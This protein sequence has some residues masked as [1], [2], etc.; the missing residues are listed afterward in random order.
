MLDV[1]PTCCEDFSA[2]ASA[3][4][5]VLSSWK[6]SRESLVASAFVANLCT[7]VSFACSCTHIMQLSDMSPA[8]GSWMQTYQDAAYRMHLRNIAPCSEWNR[9]LHC[10]SK[11]DT[12][13]A[14]YNFNT[15]QLILVIFGRDVADRV[16]YGMVICY[17]TSPN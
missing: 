4:L 5:P 6:L 10:V 7:R 2:T 8:N 15:R 17:S 12:D 13:V 9:Q 3:S 14:Q 11:N 16:C 1:G